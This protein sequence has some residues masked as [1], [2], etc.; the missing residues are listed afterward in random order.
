MRAF[1]GPRPV[2]SLSVRTTR[3]EIAAAFDGARWGSGCVVMGDIG[4][5]IALDYR[6]SGAIQP[7]AGFWNSPS[8]MS[9]I[10]P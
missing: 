4:S 10:T 8:C 9:M 6:G 2:Y 5:E 7:P 3:F 1:V